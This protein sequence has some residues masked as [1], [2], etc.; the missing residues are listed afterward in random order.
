M[1]VDCPGGTGKV[2]KVANWAVLYFLTYNTPV[3]SMHL[4]S[5]R[6]KEGGKKVFPLQEKVSTSGAQCCAAR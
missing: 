3:N 5:E 6:Q 4:G 2:L 1:K